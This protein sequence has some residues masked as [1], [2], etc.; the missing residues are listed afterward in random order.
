MAFGGNPE[1]DA[2]YLNVTPS[3]NDGKTVHR[4]VIS[5]EVPVDGFWSIIV[6][7][8]KGYLEQ[9]P[10]NAYSL[11]S[12]TA[13]KSAHGLIIIQLGRCDG[14][15]ANCL[16]PLSYKCGDPQRHLEIPRGAACRLS[17]RSTECLLLTP[18]RHLSGVMRFCLG[19]HSGRSSI[20]RLIR[21][22]ERE[23]RRTL[24][25]RSLMTQNGGAQRG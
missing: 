11:N 20:P 19:A 18:S 25:R 22:R 3:K 7:N 23:S 9:N 14:K 4:L 10:Y 13:K 12:I 21:A 24:S 5:D 1:K 8:D 6:Y 17:S 16:T 2:L 15:I